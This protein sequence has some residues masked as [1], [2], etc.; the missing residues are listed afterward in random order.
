MELFFLLDGS[1]WSHHCI[2]LDLPSE[3][4]RAPSRECKATDFEVPE[5][6]LN[7]L[8]NLS[9]CFLKDIAGKEGNKRRSGIFF[10]GDDHQTRLL[11]WSVISLLFSNLI[12]F[13]VV[14]ALCRPFVSIVPW[15][16]LPEI[17]GFIGCLDFGKAAFIISALPHSVYHWQDLQLLPSSSLTDL[18]PQAAPVLC[19][20]LQC[21]DGLLE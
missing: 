1:L 5:T 9:S 18:T 21:C 8:Q 4:Q 6:F 11:F 17:W 13:D 10:G 2:V 3:A 7:C 19:P 16:L 12:W 14:K 15:I 20:P